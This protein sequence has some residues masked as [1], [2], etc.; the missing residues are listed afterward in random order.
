M[1]FLGRII[2]KSKNKLKLKFFT[3][4][5]YS[6]LRQMGDTWS[7]TGAHEGSSWVHGGVLRHMW[8]TLG[9]MV[10][11]MGYMGGVLGHMWGVVGCNC[12][13]STLAVRVLDGSQQKAD[14]VKTDYSDSLLMITRLKTRM[15]QG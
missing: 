6:V 5:V 3:S 9:Y 1:H 4:L 15:K 8:G 10:G 14:V 7:S 11:V 13:S 2:N 12:Q